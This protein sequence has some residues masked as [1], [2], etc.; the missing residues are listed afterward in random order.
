[1]S[2]AVG[3]SKALKFD[4]MPISVYFLHSICQSKILIKRGKCCVMIPI[5]HKKKHINNIVRSINFDGMHIFSMSFTNIILAHTHAS[6]KHTVSQIVKWKKSR[7]GS[8][9]ICA[10][11]SVLLSFLWFVQ[12]YIYTFQAEMIKIFIY[13][14]LLFWLC[15]KCLICI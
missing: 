10:P 13:N 6:R 12:I 2:V 1:M 3:I 9:L 5:R 8:F 14:R 15:L 11:E 7:F 4:S